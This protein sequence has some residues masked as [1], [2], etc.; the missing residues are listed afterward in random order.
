MDIEFGALEEEFLVKGKYSVTFSR[1][2][3][4]TEKTKLLKYGLSFITLFGT[5]E[6]QLTLD[7]FILRV[8][9]SNNLVNNYNR[10]KAQPVDF[11]QKPTIKM[12]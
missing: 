1:T 12:N 2:D 3:I 10:K 8:Y 4:W 11:W 7:T 6:L 9:I 5:I